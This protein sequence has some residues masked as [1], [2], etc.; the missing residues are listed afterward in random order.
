MGHNANERRQIRRRPEQ[1]PLQQYRPS[2]NVVDTNPLPVGGPGTYNTHFGGYGLGWFLND[3]KGYLKASHTGGLDG[4]VTQVTLFPELKLG[5]IV[6]TNQ[7]SGGAF[8]A[9]TNEIIDSYIGDTGKDWVKLYGD[10]EKAG[11][12]GRR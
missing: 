6:L 10:A 9:V 7:Q 5:I 11:Q 4:M 12:A 3:A 8:S 2:P 1:T